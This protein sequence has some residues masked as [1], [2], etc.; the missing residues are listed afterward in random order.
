MCSHLFF[1]TIPAYSADILEAGQHV[2]GSIR[3]NI[4]YNL[5][6]LNNVFFFFSFVLF[7][8]FGLTSLACNNSSCAPGY[9]FLGLNVRF[10][11]IVQIRWFVNMWSDCLSV[12]STER[13]LSPPL[14]C[15]VSFFVSPRSLSNCQSQATTICSPEGAQISRESGVI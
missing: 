4:S 8:H 12:C 1:P 15:S 10:H 5:N 2:V 7:L 13:Y 14:P 6:N 9:S 11:G 3:L